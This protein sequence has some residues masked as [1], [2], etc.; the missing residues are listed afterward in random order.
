MP[1]IAR[2]RFWECLWALDAPL[3]TWTLKGPGLPSWVAPCHAPYKPRGYQIT[4]SL[5]DAI[6]SPAAGPA[7]RD[8]K[9]VPV[10]IVANL[11]GL[12]RQTLYRARDGG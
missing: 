2:P 8:D 3:D 12:S 10:T 9:R 5:F 6:G 7:C 4:C 11:T 1:I